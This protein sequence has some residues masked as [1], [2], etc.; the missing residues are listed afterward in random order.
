MRS[1][2]ATGRWAPLC[3]E[4]SAT[5]TSLRGRMG[6][7][8]PIALACCL[9]LLAVPAKAEA[10]GSVPDG[11]YGVMFDGKALR[12]PVSVQQKQFALM[13]QSGVETVRAT[14]NWA[15]VQPRRRSRLD[16]RRID[17]LVAIAA[18]RR[19]TVLPVVIY[20]P[21][22]ARAFPRRRFSPPR[23]GPYAAFLRAAVRRYRPGG[24]FWTKRPWLPA[25]PIRHWQV[26]NE[27]TLPSF[28]R[29]P[30]KS[31]YAWPRGYV[32]L[33]KASNRAIKGADRN[34]KTVT[35]G[36]VGPSWTEFRRLYRN[37]AKG[38]FD[39]AALHVYPQT[40]VRVQVA[41][42]RVLAELRRAR[43][44]RA[45]IFLTEVSF[46][47]SRGKAKP[48]RGQRQETSASMARRL[49]EL[50]ASVI[51]SRKR[52]RLDRVY[53]Y[54]WASDYVRRSSNFNFAG[55]VASRDGIEFKPQPALEAYRSSAQYFHGCPTDAFG[56]CR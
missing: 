40:L 51:S 49:E 47:A 36:L 55:L 39:V 23:V 2:P 42:R 46:P 1:P 53:W 21:G 6:V 5:P 38:S 20:A 30:K 12:A 19:I 3:P 7:R 37:G 24:V 8:L 33:L 54:T 44:R 31:S 22:W 9:A 16:W 4:P 13:A 28:W 50:Y 52:T 32:R 29:T 48:I 18:A 43:D 26:W 11:F 41:V 27:P 34:A 56:V 45:R 10:E 17:Q 35:A 15:R 14:F 25:R